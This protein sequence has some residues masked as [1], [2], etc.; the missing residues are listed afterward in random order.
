MLI[1]F[2]Y[3]FT[4]DHGTLGSKCTWC[5][6]HGI[7]CIVLIKELHHLN[8][9]IIHLM[10]KSFFIYFVS[11]SSCVHSKFWF[12]MFNNFTPLYSVL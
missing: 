11:L 1:I 2:C 5:N 4:F 3:L 6:Y 12:I 10:Y 9:S 8:V 7:C